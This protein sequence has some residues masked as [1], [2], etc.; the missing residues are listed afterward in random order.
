M[1]RAKNRYIEELKKRPWHSADSELSELQELPTKKKG[2]PLLIGQELDRQVRVYLNAVRE[3]GGVAVG[4]GIVMKDRKFMACGGQ[5]VLSKDWA[6]YVLHRMGLVKRRSSTKAKV[7][8]EDFE[9]LKKQFL[10]DIKQMD[11]I[12]ADLVINFDQTGCASV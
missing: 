1:R 5:D 3:R 8:V 9:E 12:P 7:V 11:E 10:Q 2:R 6:K 4:T